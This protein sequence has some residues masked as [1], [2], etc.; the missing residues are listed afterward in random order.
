[1]AATRQQAEHTDGHSR[2]V[3][4]KWQSPGYG[5]KRAFQHERTKTNLGVL[6]RQE[7]RSTNDAVAGTE[8]PYT[9]WQQKQNENQ[10]QFHFRANCK[11]QVKKLPLFCKSIAQV[12]CTAPATRC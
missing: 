7:C 12:C 4:T 11:A 9:G 10:S 5:A 1:M 2:G 6:F 8:R 3:K